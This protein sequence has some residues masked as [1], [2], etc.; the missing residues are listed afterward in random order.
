[1]ADNVEIT[2]GNG[3]VIRTDDIGDGQQVQFVK[4]MDGTDVDRQRP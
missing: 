3:T 2:K 4:L 1:M